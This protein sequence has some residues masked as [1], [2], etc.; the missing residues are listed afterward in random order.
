[1]EWSCQ[2]ALISAGHPP[3]RLEKLAG[4]DPSTYADLR[5]VL[6]PSLRL[7]SSKYPCRRIWKAN[8]ADTTDGMPIDLRDEPDRL[9]IL[10]TSGELRLYDLSIGELHFL[11]YVLEGGN[12]GTAVDR[13]L[14]V[15][16]EFDAGAALRRAVSNGALVDCL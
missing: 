5:F 10:R 11:R 3:F 1:L 14:E 8:L 9:A 13:T 7:F 15:D 6:H 16:L 4:L 12:F 2:E